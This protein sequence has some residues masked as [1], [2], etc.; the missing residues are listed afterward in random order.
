[1]EVMNEKEMM[2]RLAVMLD[3]CDEALEVAAKAEARREAGKA[4]RQVTAKL[5]HERARKLVAE[6]FAML[7]ME[8]AHE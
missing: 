2:R 1:M 8:D 7:G 3:A 5:R 4:M 6:A